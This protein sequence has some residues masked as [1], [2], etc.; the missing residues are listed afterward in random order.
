MK[1]KMLSRLSALLLVGAMTVGLAACG[2]STGGAASAGGTST[3]AT[4]EES[5]EL[6]GSS[7]ATIRLKVGT[8][9]A[10]DGHYVLGLIE[11]QN[12]GGVLRR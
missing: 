7:S 2:N 10:P 6:L 8:T 3:G 11:M 5:D 1:V 4:S 12:A 9:T